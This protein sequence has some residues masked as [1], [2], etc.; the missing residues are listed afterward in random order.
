MSDWWRALNA[1][2]QLLVV[3]ASIFVSGAVTFLLVLEPLAKDQKMLDGRL[4]AERASFSRIL[5]YAKEAKAIRARTT[6]SE[7]LSIDRSQSFL[8]ILNRTSSEH[9]LQNDVKRIVPNGV[10]KASV[11]F[12]KVAFDLLA[13]WLVDLQTKNHV[14]VARI[15]V[16]KTTEPGIVR[17][18]VN[19]VR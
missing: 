12:D 14:S 10:D 15:T 19:L 11:V 2:E 1:R 7:M 8:S 3:C 6:D 17:A 13:A 5:Q 16:D 4:R 9:R 18:N